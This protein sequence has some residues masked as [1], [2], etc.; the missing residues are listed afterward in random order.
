[1]LRFFPADAAPLDQ[2]GR[3]A[4]IEQITP[5]CAIQN[6][7]GSPCHQ[8]ELRLRDTVGLHTGVHRKDVIFFWPVPLKREVLTHAERALIFHGQA[9]HQGGE[10]FW[11]RRPV[12]GG[13]NHH[14]A[15]DK[16]V[17]L[18]KLMLQ[19]K[20]PAL[21]IT[22]EFNDRAARQQVRIARLTLHFKR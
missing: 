16:V 9:A 22:V 7:G 20:L 1:M 19:L 5:Q 17:A 4:E 15:F 21:V 14:I 8:A 11:Q 13:E 3:R 12:A 2:G 6:T 10:Q 18:V